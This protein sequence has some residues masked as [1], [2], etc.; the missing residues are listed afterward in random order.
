MFSSDNGVDLID[1]RMK[2]LSEA[3]FDDLDLIL[4]LIIK[5]TFFNEIVVKSDGLNFLLECGKFFDFLFDLLNDV[6]LSK[7]MI[8]SSSGSKLSSPE[9]SSS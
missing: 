7:E 2:G 3:S 1:M 8:T 9:S 6:D 4:H 5:P